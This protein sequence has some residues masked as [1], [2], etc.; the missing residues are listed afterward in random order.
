M[1]LEFEIDNCGLLAEFEDNIFE[2]A[3]IFI[4]A[5]KDWID[6]TTWVLKTPRILNYLN[7]EY[8]SFDR[9][10]EARLSF[11]DYDEEYL[12]TQNLQKLTTK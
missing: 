10:A 3:Y 6:C 11:D 8:F 12:K 5:L 2:K 9:E 4:P 1:M 7:E